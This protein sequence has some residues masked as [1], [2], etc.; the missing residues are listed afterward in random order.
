MEQQHGNRQSRRK[1]KVDLAEL[2]DA[3]EFG[4]EF[5]EMYHCLDL[6]TGEAVLISDDISFTLRQVYEESGADST[7]PM[8]AFA[9]L[10]M[11]RKELSLERGALL[12]VHEIE[13]GFSDRFIVIPQ[14]ETREAYQDMVDF[15]DTVEDPVLQKLL[16]V[17]I[18]GQGAFRRFRTV[19]YDYPEEREQW[20]AF[21]E[22]R[23][24][25]RVL[26]WLAS[27]GIEPILE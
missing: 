26:D 6:E 9:A 24:R 25:R 8:E 5:G 4:S 21:K 10:L 20:F 27:E 16:E 19:L 23:T 7:M 11:E 2:V 1:L 17:A 13:G 12:A 15:V 14:L 22:A 18:D 3:F